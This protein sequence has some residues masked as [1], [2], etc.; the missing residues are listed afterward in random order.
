MEVKNM[1]YEVFKMIMELQQLVSFSFAF[2]LTK[3]CVSYSYL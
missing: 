2:F 1:S 3:G